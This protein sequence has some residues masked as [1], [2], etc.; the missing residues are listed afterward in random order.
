[1]FMR[2][3][4]G[5]WALCFVSFLACSE[6]AISTAPD[7]AGGMDSAVA[8]PGDAD[9]PVD[10]AFEP[11]DGM[12]AETPASRTL[13]PNG[14]TL[15]LDGVVATF[16]KNALA[17]EARITL[18]SVAAP[19]SGFELYSGAYALE[20]SNVA[21]SLPVSIRMPFSGD[22]GKAGAFWSEAGDL[23]YALVGGAPAATVIVF[24][25]ARLGHGF[26]ANA[27]RYKEPADTACLSVAVRSRLGGVR[28]VASSVNAFVSVQDCRGRPLSDLTTADFTVTEDDTSLPEEVPITL[29]PNRGLRLVV[30][31][32][33]DM[34]G[35]SNLLPQIKAAA[36]AMLQR[37]IDD[38]IPADVEITLFSGSEYPDR[39]LAP[40]NQLQAV[41]SQLQALDTYSPA[42]VSSRNLQGALVYAL[43]GSASRAEH[44]QLL[45]RGGALTQTFVVAV[46]KGKDTAGYKTAEEVA[47]A[48]ARHGAELFVLNLDGGGGS[49]TQL[50][51][52]TPDWLITN[53][54]SEMLT[55]DLSAFANRIARR[56]TNNYLLAY[57]SPKR[58][59]MHRA[60]FRVGG[61]A[62]ST[63]SSVL[64]NAN[65]FAS[66]C[67]R[68]QLVNVCDDR[69][70]G[71]LGCG[72]CFD[73]L[74]Q[75]STDNHCDCKCENGGT[76]STEGEVVRCV[77]PEGW[78][79]LLCTIAS[80][81]PVACT[82]AQCRASASFVDCAGTACP[83]ITP[84]DF[85]CCA[86][87]SGDG[88]K[89][90]LSCDASPTSCTA[91]L[92]CDGAEDCPVGNFCVQGGCLTTDRE[93]YSD[94]GIGG[95]LYPS[96][97]VCRTDSDCPG[98]GRCSGTSTL[99]GIKVCAC[100]PPALLS[101]GT[102]GACI[103]PS[104]CSSACDQNE[105]CKGGTCACDEADM[106]ARCEDEHIC[107]DMERDLNHCGAC[108]HQCDRGPTQQGGG[109]PGVR[110]AGGTCT[111]RTC[112]ADVDLP[113]CGGHSFGSWC[114]G[115]R[116]VSGGPICD[117]VTKRCKAP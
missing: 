113:C 44:L 79:G 36:I 38:A 73:D 83:L 8:P 70:C 52:L 117:Q 93:Y 28:D 103:L 74:T 108:W 94:L 64:F 65:G 17:A 112:G 69:E 24:E 33:L 77:C 37:F 91:Q 45:N 81:L 87:A 114:D 104:E 102:S 78:S 1:M 15:E 13:G 59:G 86:Q 4:F 43:E 88:G 11:S 22:Q 75:C 84:T 16:P 62:S 20:P 89:P 85:V 96:P 80:R 109:D 46:V 14:G 27:V 54:E 25:V 92:A 95:D 3:D 2:V 19:P 31:L 10:G 98:E 60:G 111:P 97:Y 18:K 5:I 107:T 26:V 110:C 30:N 21:L 116:G 58:G 40:T 72:T 105:L 76:C 6:P 61:S 42:D 71:G 47:G 99:T 90:T 7:A 100:E 66:G 68:E 51:R 34:S 35:P 115:E 9:V 41:L 55:R 53:T 82:G 49:A 32:V 29:L 48:H 23:T 57:C 101:S 56:A 50:A 12:A 106:R 39:W 67:T 63:A